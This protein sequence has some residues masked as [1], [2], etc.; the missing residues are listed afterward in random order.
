MSKEKSQIKLNM[1]KL[2]RRLHAKIDRL[3][4]EE[5]V[6]LAKEWEVKIPPIILGKLT[7]YNIN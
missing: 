6:D 2:I 4:F 1:Q 3:S 7:K 5:Q